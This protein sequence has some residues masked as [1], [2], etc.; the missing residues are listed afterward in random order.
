MGGAA[1]A[2][3]ACLLAAAV[4]DYEHQGLNNDFMVKSSHERAIRYNDQHVN[5][6]HHVAAAFGLLLRPELNFLGH[7]PAQDFGRVRGLAIEL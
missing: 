1:F 4:H 3:M 6:Q 5:E 2:R 7:L